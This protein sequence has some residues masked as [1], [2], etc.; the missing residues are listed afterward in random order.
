MALTLTYRGALL[1]AVTAGCLAL[2][3]TFGGRSLN[4]V[5][6]PAVVAL[7]AAVLTVWRAPTPS[8]ERTVPPDGHPGETHPVR[9]EVADC[10]AGIYRLCDE[11]SGGLAAAGETHDVT[12]SAETI[13]Y[14]LRYQHRGDHRLGPPSVAVTDAL[15]LVERTFTAAEEPGQVLVYPAIVDPPRAVRSLL[16]SVVDVDHRPGRDEFDALREYVRGDSLR[17]VHWKSSARR[18][19]DDLV[20][21]EFDDRAPTDAVRIAVAPTGNRDAVDAAARAAASVATMLFQEGVEVGLDTPNA[22]LEPAVG[23][24]H[25]TAILATL[26]RLTAGQCDAAEATV[27]ITTSRGDAQVHADGRSVPFATDTGASERRR[28]GRDGVTGHRPAD[29]DRSTG[30]AP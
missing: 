14:E 17:D 10:G 4:A 11:V 24:E 6:A 30:V 3:A 28:N 13:S 1:L 22:T 29:A 7:G 9:L 26:A 27:R 5:V 19:G 15:G 21:K 12:D 18:P 16:E 8:I 20:V 2:A 25:R 23:P